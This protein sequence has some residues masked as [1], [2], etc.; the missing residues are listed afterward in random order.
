MIKEEFVAQCQK[1]SAVSIEASDVEEPPGFVKE[2]SEV[3]SDNLGCLKKYVHRIKIKEG[4]VPVV[5]KNEMK[6]RLIEENKHWPLTARALQIAS[7]GF[8]ALEGPGLAAKE[9]TARPG[10]RRS[11]LPRASIDPG[12][13]HKGIRALYNY[14][15]SFPSMRGDHNTRQ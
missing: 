4:S 2:F 12:P 6:R 13:R 7:G 15:T 11:I 3:F 14:M 1:V 9:P 8:W 5:A 10:S